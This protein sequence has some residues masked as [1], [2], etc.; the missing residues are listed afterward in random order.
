MHRPTGMMLAYIMRVHMCL[1][2][3][4]RG[5]RW[6]VGN[7]LAH[8]EVAKGTEAESEARA[9]LEAVRVLTFALACAA[10]S[11]GPYGCCA[12]VAGRLRCGCDA[13]A[14]QATGRAIE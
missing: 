1:C 13:T 14:M 10:I 5:H 9:V 3:H 2:A 11:P 12:G 6:L 7:S 8:L 4:G